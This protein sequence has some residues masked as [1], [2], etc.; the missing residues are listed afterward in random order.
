MVRGTTW[1]WFPVVCL[2]AGLAACL[3]S[4]DGGLERGRMGRPPSQISFRGS[5]PLFAFKLMDR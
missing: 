2:L 4:R 5:S 3:A 1:R